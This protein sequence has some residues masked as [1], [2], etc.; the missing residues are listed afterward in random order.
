M[1]PLRI[2]SVLLVVLSVIGANGVGC[3]LA[4][5]SDRIALV[6]GNNDYKRLPPLKNA[7][8][9]ASGIA[10]ALEAK[11]WEVILR[12]NAT[13][14]DMGRA[15]ETFEGRLATADA[16]LMFYAGHGVQARG[17]NWLIPADANV[18]SE[19]DLKYEGVSARDILEAMKRSGT[20]LNIVILDAC[21]DNPLRQSARSASRGLAVPALPQGIK[22]TAVMFSAAPGETAEDGPAGGNGVFTGALLETLNQPGLKLEEVFKRTAR[23]VSELTAN[24]QRPWFNSSIYGD[25]YFSETARSGAEPAP[26]PAPAARPNA[27]EGSQVEIVFWQSIQDSDQP[28]LFESYLAQYPDGAF[29]PLARAKLALLR[30]PVGVSP[31]AAA[32]SDITAT[33]ARETNEPEAAAKSPPVVASRPPVQAPPVA[34]GDRARAEAWLA[35][36]RDLLRRNLTHFLIQTRTDATAFFQVQNI[37]KADL[38]EVT[39]DG[40]VVEIRYE[41]SNDRIPRYYEGETARFLMRFDS[42]GLKFVEKLALRG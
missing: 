6:I 35:D 30:Q 5:A 21:R 34:E 9:D 31:P 42:D 33:A 16:G 17:E 39:A 4:S 8:N 14:R 32:R 19:V 25:F 40:Y 10:A 12:L 28:S 27:A 37:W 23:R 1:Q 20:P 13:Q 26:A 22:G 2:L 11:G 15:I 41:A 29:A 24:R 36:E 3:S 18:E 7:A 38:V